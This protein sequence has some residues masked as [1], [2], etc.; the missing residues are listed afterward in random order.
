MKFWIWFPYL[1]LTFLQ[2]LCLLKDTNDRMVKDLLDLQGCKTKARSLQR[3]PGQN[4]TC[5]NKVYWL[6]YERDLIETLI[7]VL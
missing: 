4:S 2:V 1:D 7:F 6:V 5:S 3:E